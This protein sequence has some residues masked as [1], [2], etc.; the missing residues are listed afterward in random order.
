MKPTN[1][2]GLPA[3]L[4]PRLIKPSAW[5]EGGGLESEADVRAAA[6]SLVEERALTF[7]DLLYR[8]EAGYRVYDYLFAD[9]L[10]R[11]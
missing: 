7:H 3:H 4:S 10:R 9:Y 11:S 5:G 1:P 2:S 8:D 6:E